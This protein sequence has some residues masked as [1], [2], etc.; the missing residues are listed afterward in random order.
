V[1]DTDTVP[2]M[3]PYPPASPGLVDRPDLARRLDEAG[4][5]RVVSVSAAPG[6]GK[7]TQ[8]AAWA[9]ERGAAW[10]TVGRGTGDP[11]GPAGLPAI[12]DIPDAP[13][14]VVDGVE[15]LPPAGAAA[16]RAAA[17]EALRL[18]L[19]GRQR[20]SDGLAEVGAAALALTPAQ[21]AEVLCAALGPDGSAL[22]AAVAIRIE[23][24]GDEIECAPW[25]GSCCCTTRC[26]SAPSSAARARPV[27]S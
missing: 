23:F 8:V 21:T 5:R 11:A 14:L 15:K 2:D 7:T 27:T 10:R 12:T 25:A 16:L 1:R 22:A 6:Y 26:R 3:P 9:R 19:L 20:V 4:A 18:V 17:P 24:F 13:V